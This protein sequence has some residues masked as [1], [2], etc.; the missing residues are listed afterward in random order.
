VAAAA[1]LKTRDQSRWRIRRPC[2]RRTPTPFRLT[3]EEE[4]VKRLFLTLTLLL[5]AAQ[6]A[7]AQKGEC[8]N[9]GPQ[10]G[11]CQEPTNSVKTADSRGDAGQTAAYALADI[12]R[13]ELYFTG[14][15]SAV[16]VDTNGNSKYD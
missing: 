4:A 1:T 13:P 8:Q 9:D 2:A 7:P 16:G 14:Q 12:D 11:N 5:L 3:I 15:G 10:R 6:L